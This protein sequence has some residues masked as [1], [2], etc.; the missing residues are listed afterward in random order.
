MRIYIFGPMAGYLGH[1]FD[2]FHAKARELRAKGHFVYNPAEIEPDT[3]KNISDEEATKH[4]NGAY[5]NCLR[6]ELAWICDEA[7]GMYGLIGW[8][9]SKGANA[10]HFTGRAVG[11]NFFYEAAL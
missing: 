5:R 3:Y 6:Q 9:H 7:E 11:V 2:A 4:H 8:E 10:E 1:N